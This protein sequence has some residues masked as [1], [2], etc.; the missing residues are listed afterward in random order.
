MTGF[1]WWVIRKDGAEYICT[2]PDC[3]DD[4]GAM[5]S[6]GDIITFPFEVIQT[7]S[8]A[9]TVWAEAQFEHYIENREREEATRATLE[10]SEPAPDIL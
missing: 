3:A 10:R 2:L 8:L 5:T 4:V 1:I 6:Y 7:A 9:E